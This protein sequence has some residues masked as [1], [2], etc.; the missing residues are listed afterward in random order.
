MPGGRQSWVEYSVVGRRVVE[1][2]RPDEI[3]SF[4][5][6]QYCW[7]RGR[8]ALALPLRHVDY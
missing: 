8:L 6:A 3:E 1:K 7:Q 5:T 2:S 4:V